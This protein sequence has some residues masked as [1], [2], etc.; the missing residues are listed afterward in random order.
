MFLLYSAAF[1]L[2]KA[3]FYH[4][5]NKNDKFQYHTKN[6]KAISDDTFDKKWR[7]MEDYTWINLAGMIIFLISAVMGCVLFFLGRRTA[8]SKGSY[9]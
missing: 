4:S 9:V 8:R 1:G 6:G 3:I 7:N 5:Y 2:M